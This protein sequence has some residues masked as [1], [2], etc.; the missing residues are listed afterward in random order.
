MHH[1][2]ATHHNYYYNVFTVNNWTVQPFS[3]AFLW[4]FLHINIQPTC[5]L[6]M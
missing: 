3:F 1:H 4:V 5:I 2:K 6:I